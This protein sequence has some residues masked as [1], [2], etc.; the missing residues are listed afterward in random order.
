[1]PEKGRGKHLV[2]YDAFL[3][4]S[5]FET[6]RHVGKKVA[7]LK[8]VVVGYLITVNLSPLHVGYIIHLAGAPTPLH[9]VC[10]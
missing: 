3:A 6:M 9:V 5:W 10:M 1:M 8:S 2:T 7:K 4:G